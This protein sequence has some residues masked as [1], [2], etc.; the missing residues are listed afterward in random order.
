MLVTQRHPPRIRDQVWVIPPE[1]E[2]EEDA[3]DKAWDRHANEAC[4]P[5]GRVNRP[6]LPQCRG[7][8]QRD[9]HNHR[10]DEGDD[11]KLERDGERRHDDSSHALVIADRRAEV[12]VQNL[13]GPIPELHRDW[14]RKPVLLVV[15]RERLRGGIET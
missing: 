4:E 15:C 8:T 9:P 12:S 5:N 1:D 14:A 7:H 10:Q 2:E 3:E 13:L 11:R 6:P